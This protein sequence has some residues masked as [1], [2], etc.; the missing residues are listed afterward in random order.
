M[1]TTDITAPI[2]RMKTLIEAL[3]NIGLVYDYDLFSRTN[4]ATYLVSKIGGNDTLRAWWIS[5]PTMIG[6]PMVQTTAGYIERTWR[7]TIYGIEGLTE[8]GDSLLTLR[9]N[10]LAVSDAID[11]EPDLNGSCHRTRPTSW[12]V[13]E[14]RAAWAGIG[15][16]F[17]QL[18]K[19]VVTLSTP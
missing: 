18:T 10:A 1:A 7:Y 13:N 14:N 4:L 3:P 5:G 6:K 19:E 12:V 8:G 9:A 11:A 2:A 15:A 16:S 17:A